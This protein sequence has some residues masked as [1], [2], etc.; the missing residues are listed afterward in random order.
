MTREE[1]SEIIGYFVDIAD[2]G[3]A[4][5][6][7]AHCLGSADGIVLVALARHIGAV[8][9]LGCEAAERAAESEEMT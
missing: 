3:N 1:Y 9:S 7:R 4:I 2:L 5:E 6:V 8:A